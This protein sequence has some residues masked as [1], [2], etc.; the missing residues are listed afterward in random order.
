M[1]HVLAVI[2]S[3]ISDNVRVQSQKAS[4]ALVESR[5]AVAVGSATTGQ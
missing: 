1:V 4:G 3:D 2:M 5:L